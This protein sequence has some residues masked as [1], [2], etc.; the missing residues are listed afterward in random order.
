MKP[1]L[2]LILCMTLASAAHASEWVSPQQYAT[3]K[4]PAA[5]GLKP[6]PARPAYFNITMKDVERKVAESMVEDGVAEHVEVNVMPSGT[7][8]FFKA[9]HPI[10]L[11]VHALQI[12][13]G[14]KRWQAEAYVVADGKTQTVRP[15]AGRYDEMVNVPVLSRQ[16]GPKDIIAMEDIEFRLVASRKLRKDTVTDVDQ[17]LGKS[18]RRLI[19]GDRMVR[20]SEIVDAITVE[21]NAQVEM[22]YRTPSMSIRTM[23]KALENGGMGDLIRVMNHDTQRSISARVTGDG[24]VEVTPTTTMIN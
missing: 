3:L 7:P 17:L 9:D 10:A 11:V 18:A 22:L 23:G 21:K 13:P 19:S 4:Q 20:Q 8:V 12:D 14:A 16:M 1:S 15:I 2:A 5:E 6:L 24:R